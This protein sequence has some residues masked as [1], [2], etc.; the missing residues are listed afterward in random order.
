MA[1]PFK[2]QAT[3]TVDH[4]HVTIAAIAP[5]INTN[6]NIRRPDSIDGNKANA[7]GLINTQR[8]E[9]A[10][11]KQDI[12]VARAASIE[13]V[14][15]ARAEITAATEALGL[16]PNEVFPDTNMAPESATE[17][18]MGSA[19]SA[20]GKGSMATAASK[21]M[22]S[23]GIADTVA[24]GMRGKPQEEVLQAIQATLV[25][26][27]QAPSEENTFSNTGVIRD[28]NAPPEGAQT[29]INWEKVFESHPNALNEIMYAEADNFASFPEIAEMDAALEMIEEVETG[30]DA[31]QRTFDQKYISPEL[32]PIIAAHPNLTDPVCALGV[33][34]TEHP[35][36]YPMQMDELMRDLK[37]QNFALMPVAAFV[38]EQMAQN[39]KTDEE[40]EVAAPSA[41]TPLQIAMHG[42]GSMA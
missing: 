38:K 40:L 24:S 33:D 7:A 8:A 12:E 19:I 28:A 35:L 21:V 31:A 1:D 5:N 22:D 2:T 11:G 37:E 25:V 20:T 34:L 18:V 23:M 29:Q 36:G 10:S 41:L 9:M 6:V 14:R 15:S 30:L 27:S 32:A 17:L 42:Y 3:P 26:Y 4:G 16:D 39:T 13:A